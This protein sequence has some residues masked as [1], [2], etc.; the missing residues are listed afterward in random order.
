MQ[1]K[2]ESFARLLHI[3]DDLR[4]Q[5]PWDRKQTIQSLRMLTIEE[6][7]ELIDAIDSGDMQQ[8][9][10]E[11]GDIMLHLVFYAKIASEKN[12]FDIADVISTLCD[13]LIARHPHIY[14]AV[15]VKDEN[16]V[17]ANWEKLKLNEG[18]ESVMQGVPKSLP[19][20]VK[21]FRL[22]DKAAQVGFDWENAG[23]V[24]QKVE[25]EYRELDAEIA[26]GNQKKIEEE[27][28]D[29][30]FALV[31]Y[32]RFLKIDPER[33]LEQCNRKFIKRFQYIEQRARELNKPLTQMNLEEM[34]AYWNEAK[35][36]E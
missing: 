30:L 12:E 17:K 16:E 3:M 26:K 31:N 34:D 14:A 33:A 22:Q 18:K 6:L 20:L 5:C 2:T 15:S 27:F 29:L 19:A 23:Q 24:K 25:E 35:K 9:K 11:L 28:G 13:K 7:Y 1:N 36:S 8:L 21:A 4:E 10:E 32:A